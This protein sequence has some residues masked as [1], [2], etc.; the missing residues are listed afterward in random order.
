[1]SV[2]NHLM[3]WMGQLRTES[4]VT[5]GSTSA[6]VEEDVVS[7][8]ARSA[9][10]REYRD[11]L[12]QLLVRVA[13]YCD[14]VEASEDEEAS[15]DGVKGI[16]ELLSGLETVGEVGRE[17]AGHRWQMDVEAALA[18]VTGT[19]AGK[20]VLG[21]MP[22]GKGWLRLNRLLAD[23][24][25][26]GAR[27]QALGER[28]ADAAGAARASE[29]REDA[30]AVGHYCKEMADWLMPR[31]SGPSAR[32]IP[33]PDLAKIRGRAGASTALGGLDI[34]P[35]LDAHEFL[36]RIR[37]FGASHAVLKTCI[38]Q[39][40]KVSDAL[41]DPN[42]I[43]VDAAKAELSR[44]K[45]TVDLF[46]L[47]ATRKSDC[48]LF[49]IG[50]DLAQLKGSLV[51]E[52][53]GVA[54]V[55]S[56]R[57][58]AAAAKL[59]EILDKLTRTAEIRSQLGDEK[60][61]LK[62]QLK[63]E[64]LRTISSIGH[65]LSPQDLVRLERCRV[66]DP[67]LPALA[68]WC[69]GMQ[70]AL[71]ALRQVPDSPARYLRRLR[72]L[73]YQCARGEILLGGMAG[74]ELRGGGTQARRAKRMQ[75]LYRSQVAWHPDTNASAMQR[76]LESPAFIGCLQVLDRLTPHIARALPE[77]ADPGVVG[78]LEDCM[79]AWSASGAMAQ[80]HLAER[81]RR[82]VKIDPGLDLYQHRKGVEAAMRD[83][84]G[85]A[86][87]IDRSGNPAI[88]SIPGVMLIV[89][90]GAE[91][92]MARV[93]AEAF[94]AAG[95]KII[96][97]KLQT[98]PEASLVK[99]ARVSFPS[100]E[101]FDVSNGW[102]QD[103]GRSVMSANDV[104]IPQASLGDRDQ[105]AGAAERAGVAIF[106]DTP[107]H[108]TDLY[109]SSSSALLNFLRE[110]LHQICGGDRHKLFHAT[111]HMNQAAQ[112]GVLEAEMMAGYG[113]FGSGCLQHGTG[114]VDDGAANQNH[115]DN[116]G[117]TRHSCTRGSDGLLH[118]SSSDRKLNVARLLHFGGK[119]GVAHDFD[120]QRSSCSVDIVWKVG[121]D[122]KVTL[123]GAH[124][125]HILVEA[126]APGSG[127]D[128][129]L[130]VPDVRRTA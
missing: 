119:G 71:R 68:S 108:R 78:T 54:S 63:A 128:A 86:I 33:L 26:L 42:G 85:I 113:V 110:L 95:R 101:S 118:F 56:G 115:H 102:L 122:G 19:E 29:Q 47:S 52:A 15:D 40:D 3:S 103:V 60:R 59:S 98:P 109:R 16:R 4:P 57:E 124:R 69:R 39:L 70:D 58:S 53:P 120:P 50:D 44:F 10:H 84:I 94:D 99:R 2:F 88:R 96:T 74:Q 51:D 8:A 49:E 62:A 100:G 105:V 114:R 72:S 106:A 48:L 34:K 43:D 90:E 112:A 104:Q 25:A 75:A 107:S 92:R 130:T 27:L 28:L 45:Q 123:M 61:P 77:W 11:Y 79:M 76:R 67:G 121:A 83:G 93:C 80:A 24:P 20:A 46:S 17:L 82:T 22:G 66:L 14:R 65:L 13:H 9:L 87:A 5:T 89:G 38:G 32:C 1:M 6:A 23:T 31:E 7:K 73:E 18:D 35:L 36:L 126:P 37:A 125:T 21:A 64:L 30:Q 111:Q 117:G 127:A 91:V 55:K 116:K 41:S 12:S 97:D 129:S 81:N